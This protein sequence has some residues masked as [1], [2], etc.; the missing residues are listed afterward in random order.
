M[1]ER[2][3][4][5]EFNMF[6]AVAPLALDNILSTSFGLNKEIQAEKDNEYLRH[7]IE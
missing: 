3:N 6:D 7:C 2:L 4:G 5:K 1:E